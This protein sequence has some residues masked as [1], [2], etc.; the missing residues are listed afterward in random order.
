MPADADSPRGLAGRQHR[1]GQVR[2]DRRRRKSSSTARSSGF[3]PGNRAR[4]RRTHRTKETNSTKEAGDQQRQGCRGRDGH[5]E[6]GQSGRTLRAARAGFVLLRRPACPQPSPRRLLS[7]SS[8]LSSSA[9][10][11]EGGAAGQATTRDQRPELPFCGG[12]L[13]ADRRRGWP[14]V[15]GGPPSPLHALASTRPRCPT[16][17]FRSGAPDDC[18]GRKAAHM[19]RLTVNSSIG[20]SRRDLR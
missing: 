18:L 12:R 2:S 5:E 10:R 19:G 16:S 17:L 13:P 14:R 9:L 3:T 1:F 8:F 4:S 15:G 20:I 6:R 7:S 11:P